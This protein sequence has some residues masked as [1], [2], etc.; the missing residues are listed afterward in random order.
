MVWQRL[1]VAAALA[2]V[3]LLG[4]AADDPGVMKLVL[5]VG[6]DATIS[7]GPVREFL[8]DDG[9]LVKL[10]FVENG[11]AMKGLRAGS[12]LCSYRDVAS[13]RRVVRVTVLEPGAALPSQ[14]GVR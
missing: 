6:E 3:P 4:T 8:C 9:T 14:T 1:V 2:A 12:T 11:V 10:A 13:V 5:L 7:G